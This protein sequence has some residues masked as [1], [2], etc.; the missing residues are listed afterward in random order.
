MFGRIHIINILRSRKASILESIHLITVLQLY[1]QLLKMHLESS[2]GN[3]R[4]VTIKFY[5]FSKQY[6]MLI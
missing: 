3:R 4:S 1:L 2:K 5:Y 6:N